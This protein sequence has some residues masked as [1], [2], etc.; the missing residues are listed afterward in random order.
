VDVLYD[1]ADG[2]G[3]ITLNRPAAHNSLT[4]ASLELLATY[5]REA[6]EDPAVRALVITGAGERAFCTG[7]DLHDLMPRV[8]GEE[9]LDLIVPDPSKRF[10][11]DVF[12]PVVAAVNGLCIGGGMEV[13]LGSDLRVAGRSARF[14]LGEVRWGHIPGAGSHVRLPAQVPWAIAMQLILTGEPIDAARAYEVGLVNEVVDDTDVMA[15]AMEIARRIATNAPLAVQTAKE[16]AVRALGH[17]TGFRL[18]R[19]LNE[20]V[21]RSADAAEGPLAFTQKRAP[22]WSGR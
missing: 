21:A 15:R 6:Q 16:I 19:E 3:V 17:E 18:E 8:A 1:L 5:S 7:G 20:R 13:M 4:V 10:F 14:G 12:K 9:G 11:S 22:R 2:V